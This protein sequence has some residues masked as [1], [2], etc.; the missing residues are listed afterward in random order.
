LRP[1]AQS[2]PSRNWRSHRFGLIAS[3]RLIASNNLPPKVVVIQFFFVTNHIQST[4]GTGCRHIDNIRPTPGP[5]PCAIGL[6]AKNEENSFA[7]LPLKRVNSTDMI[8]KPLSHHFVVGTLRPF[9]NP[10]AHGAR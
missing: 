5:L 8:V 2:Q 1:A 6:P 10:V 3:N 4:F 7:F 9:F